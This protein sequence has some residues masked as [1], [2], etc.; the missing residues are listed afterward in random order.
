MWIVMGY[1]VINTAWTSL[2]RNVK[3]TGGILDGFVDF[4]GQIKSV[5]CANAHAV[6]SV[7]TRT[8]VHWTQE[9]T[10]TATAF[11]S[12]M[13]CAPIALKAMTTVIIYATR[14]TFVEAMSLIPIQICSAAGMILAHLIL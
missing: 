1:V 10:P 13:T 4:A 11:A 2:A 9:T 8:C 12:L 7:V 3:T 5:T 6:S 14:M